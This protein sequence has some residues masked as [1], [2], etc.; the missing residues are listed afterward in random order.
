MTIPLGMKQAAESD[1]S[2][3]KALM[4]VLSQPVVVRPGL[5]GDR[6]AALRLRLLG[7]TER[8]QS[9]CSRSGQLH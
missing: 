6:Y 3:L 2:T 9:A 8:Q 7:M 5:A 4:T 1:F